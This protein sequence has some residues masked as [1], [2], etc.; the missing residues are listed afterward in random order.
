MFGTLHFMRYGLCVLALG[1]ACAF[2]QDDSLPAHTGF[3][4]ALPDAQLDSY[5]GGFEVVKNGMQLDATLNGNSAV[6]VL[7]GNNTITDGAFT[8]ASGLPMVIQNTGSNVSIQNA[9]IVNIQMQ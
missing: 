6:N 4:A 7:T 9:T 5:R 8:N 3:G 1:V 2:A